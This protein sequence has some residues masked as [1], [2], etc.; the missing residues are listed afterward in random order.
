MFTFQQAIAQHNAFPPRGETKSSYTL[1]TDKDCPLKPKDFRIF[2][3]PVFA[4]DTD[5]QNQGHTTG[6]KWSQK[7]TPEDYESAC[8]DYES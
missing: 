1:F 3:Y 2:C 8:E 4:L 6:G 7:S 5:L